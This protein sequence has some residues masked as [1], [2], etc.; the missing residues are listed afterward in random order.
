[1]NL[2]RAILLA[3]GLL[4]L[5]TYLALAILHLRYPFE[6]EWMEG[7]VL[8][9][10]QR[11]LSGEKIY[12]PPSSEFVPFVYTPL[13]FYLSAA[14]ST[15]LGAGF[16]PLRLVSAL[17]SLGCLIVIYQ[18]TRR[19]TGDSFSAAI[20][21]CMFAAVYEIG[22]AWLDLAR[23][24]SLFL[25]LLL[26]AVYFARVPTRISYLLA[27][28]CLSLAFL[29]KQT[30]LIVGLPLLVHSVL[31]HRRLSSWFVGITLGIA[32][33]S[34]AFLDH[35]HEGW[36]TYYI[37]LPGKDPID[38][39]AI[40]RFWTE[41]LLKPLPVAI[42]LAVWFLWKGLKQDSRERSSFYLLLAVGMVAGCWLSRVRSGGYVN[43]VLPLYALLSIIF[44]TASHR[45]LTT[46]RQAKRGSP[47]LLEIGVLS[48]MLLQFALLGYDPSR[49][50]PSR[51]DLEAGHE[52]VR[53]VAKIEGEVLIPF[54]PYLADRA[55]KRAYLAGN[56]C[57]DM[58]RAGE[59]SISSSLV[60]DVRRA[61]HAQQYEVIILDDSF[62]N[63]WTGFWP[64]FKDDI[65]V[66]YSPHRRVFARDDVFWPIAG[67]PTRPELILTPRKLGGT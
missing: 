6:L 16:F 25:C 19:E 66:Y 23:V 15:L 61:I 37:L 60:A 65:E 41:D 50:V 28:L 1:M 9:H 49:L 5:G 45:F 43:V 14:V 36:Y 3:V 67:A 10:V 11:I 53:T 26:S 8:D 34:T 17:S 56:A 31:F 12:V 24:D 55:G 57:G 51:D 7:G 13:Y 44:G 35:L 63:Y 62:L 64:T 21:A 29:A 46:V 58:F 4:Y 18:F 54:H 30:A 52:L 40:V 59:R 2:P 32:G 47:N 22:G 27:G 48:A 33:L 39:Y 42:T 38:S 20:S